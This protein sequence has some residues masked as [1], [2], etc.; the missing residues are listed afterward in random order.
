MAVFPEGSRSP[1]GEVQRFRNGAFRLATELGVPVLPIAI[2]KSRRI[3]AKKQYAP[4]DP[5]V[6][7]EVRVLP[8]IAPGEDPKSLN[9][10]AKA[11][12]VAALED[13]RGAA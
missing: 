7:V 3:M 4:Q 9:R 2:D 11:A 10:E 8:S 6:T 13:I 12:I 1:D 5:V